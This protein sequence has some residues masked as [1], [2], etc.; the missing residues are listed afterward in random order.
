MQNVKKKCIAST[1]T[2]VK[3]TYNENTKSILQADAS[4]H[5]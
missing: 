1:T 3:N 4:K 5:E 2:S